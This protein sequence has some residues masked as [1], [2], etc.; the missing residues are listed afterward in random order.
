TRNLYS[1]PFSSDN[2]T[3]RVS[4]SPSNS[5]QYR[6]PLYSLKYSSLFFSFTLA[7]PGNCT[8]LPMDSFVSAFPLSATRT[9]ISEV[10]FSWAT[11]Q[12][13]KPTNRKRHRRIRVAFFMADR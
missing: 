7:L 9:V 2:F 11:F 8:A 6:S 13:D 10:V 12:A 4:P 1:F 5:F 3:A